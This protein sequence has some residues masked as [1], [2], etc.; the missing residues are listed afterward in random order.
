MGLNDE[1]RSGDD[2]VGGRA[3]VSRARC[4]DRCTRGERVARRGVDLPRGRTNP[5]R[6]GGGRLRPADALRRARLARRQLPLRRAAGQLSSDCGERIDLPVQEA[7]LEWAAREDVAR[8]GSG[9]R[10]APCCSSTRS[11][12]TRSIGNCRSEGTRASHRKAHDGS[13]FSR[14]AACILPSF[15]LVSSGLSNRARTRRDTADPLAATASGP[16]RERVRLA[17]R[18][19]RE[20]SGCRLGSLGALSRRGAIGGKSP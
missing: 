11:T 5:R 1:P 8:S 15:L 2:V 19:D 13:L 17:G 6:D 14:S 7:L 12:T 3:A 10:D 18:D 16:S 20:S 9:D 4:E